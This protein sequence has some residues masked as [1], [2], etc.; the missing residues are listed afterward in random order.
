MYCPG[1]GTRTNEGDR[2]CR[3]CGDALPAA[4]GGEPPASAEKAAPPLPPGGAGGSVWGGE[5]PAPAAP[6]VAPAPAAP[7]ATPIAPAAAPPHPTDAAPSA[8]PRHVA[9]RIVRP[10]GPLLETAAG[11]RELAG[12]GIRF[13][14]WLI[15][16][17]VYIAAAVALLLLALA[18]VYARDGDPSD[19]AVDT[20]GNIATAVFVLWQ[21]AAAW[22][23]N[24]LG[25][26]PG[27]RAMGL[28]VV[29]EHGARPGAGRGFGRTIG[30]VVSW[31]FLGLG[32]LWAAWDD[33]KQTWHDKIAST[34]VVRL[35]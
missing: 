17:V 4:A 7:A 26:S 14:S 29:D 18:A 3:S 19:A 8:T 20:A 16:V 6:A 24:A 23:F 30:A 11:E 1:C 34:Y 13:G 5:P 27:K 33:S 15:D 25:W 10:R 21:F 22:I 28:R 35:D 9:A 32:H 2:Y 31:I 12:F